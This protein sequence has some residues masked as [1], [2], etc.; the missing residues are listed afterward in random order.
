MSILDY[1]LGKRT[2]TATVAKERLQIIL[3]HERADRSAPDFLP[4]LQQEIVQVVAKYFPIEQ[5]EV[6][7]RVQRHANYAVVELNIALPEA[8]KA[9]GS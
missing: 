4:A 1:L 5:D 6:K 9:A 3:A 8:K 2:K 7:V